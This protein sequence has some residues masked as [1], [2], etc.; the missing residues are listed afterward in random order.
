MQADQKPVIWTVVIASL[1]ILVALFIAISSVN[2]NLDL[3]TQALNNIEFPTATAIAGL[4]VIP[5][6]PSV[7]NEKV[8][9]VCELTAGCEYWEPEDDEY[10][11]NETLVEIF[12]FINISE[13]NYENKDYTEDFFESISDLTEIDEDYLFIIE[14]KVKDYQVRAYTDD[15]AEDGNWEIK[16]FMRVKYH[17]TDDEEDPEVIYVLVTSVL[18]E[19]EYDS[20]TVEEVDRK[21]EF[22]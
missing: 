20:M 10:E 14:A 3:N 1:V 16:A 5:E 6:M 2:S 12:E 7:D 17:D 9:R 13:I 4:I 11:F 21:F 15:D 22:N 19:G 8:D 18:D